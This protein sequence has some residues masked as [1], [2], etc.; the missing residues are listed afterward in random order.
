MHCLRAVD[1][2]DRL[3]DEIWEKVSGVGSYYSIADGCTKDLFR[4]RLFQSNAVLQGEGL[5]LRLE[6][7]EG[8]LE[9]HPIA[10]G[11]SSFRHAKEALQDIV[12]LRDRLFATKPIC[13]IIPDGMRGARRLAREAGMT[14]TGTVIRPLSGIPI[15]C[16]VFTW[17]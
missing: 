2:D 13:C 10:F 16:T 5:L 7:G 4:S 12:E 3:V 9:V 1:V 14:R 8:C 17:R 11:P 15:P 6:A